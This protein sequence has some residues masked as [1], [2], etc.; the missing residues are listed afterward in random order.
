[1]RNEFIVHFELIHR[2]CFDHTVVLFENQFAPV[3]PYR[4]VVLVEKLDG[5]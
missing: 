3:K 5:Q 1:M 4:K 2:H